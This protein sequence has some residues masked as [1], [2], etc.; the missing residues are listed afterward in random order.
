MDT[1]FIKIVDTL[2]S[3][4]FKE[5]GRK[6]RRIAI[7]QESHWQTSRQDAITN[8][9]AGVISL[10]E[11]GLLGSTFTGIATNCPECN[12]CVPLRINTDKFKLSRSNRRKLKSF[13]DLNANIVITDPEE[14]NYRLK[15][16]IFNL[17]R[18]YSKWRFPKKYQFSNN[19]NNFDFEISSGT[20]LLLVN[21]ED[22]KLLSFAIM[23]RDGQGANL[24][25]ISYN[26]SFQNHF[27][28]TVTLL[29]V[30]EWAQD[31]GINHIYLGATND[32][33]RLRY[34]QSYSGLETLD[35]DSEEWVDFD[36]QRHTEGPD[37][38]VI[39]RKLGVSQP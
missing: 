19:P 7:R 12:E 1:F 22:D 23:N 20:H 15:S 25:H 3:C 38:G 24:S 37:Y 8:L 11:K 39:L 16:A 10:S 14:A 28:G 36:A 9:K 13:A 2:D 6:R 21:D 26:P 29:K 33:D 30:V 27:L 17:H 32:G 31:Q 5:D 35:G 18:K 34:K 4:A